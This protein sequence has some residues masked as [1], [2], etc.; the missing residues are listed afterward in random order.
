MIHALNS[1]AT[2]CI[3]DKFKEL[4]SATQPGDDL[5]I[6]FDEARE[7]QAAFEE[8]EA[9]ILELRAVPAEA[10]PEPTHLGL[11]FSTGKMML[12]PGYEI[13]GDLDK[14]A[15]QRNAIVSDIIRESAEDCARRGLP[16]N[17][18]PTKYTVRWMLRSI[19]QSWA[20]G[21]TQGISESLLRRILAQFS[22]EELR[23][24]V[25]QERDCEF[26]EFLGPEPQIPVIETR[27][28]TPNRIR[29][30]PATVQGINSGR[31][32]TQRPRPRGA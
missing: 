25:A 27:R 12:G 19:L 15:Q 4:L 23:Y 29:K 21:E 22:P 26:P 3:L 20:R 7:L 9:E 2:D 8:L 18:H 17:D 13:S 10:E 32:A 16:V 6:T 31:S 28:V 5:L 14:E 11:L 1:A 30:A 24:Y